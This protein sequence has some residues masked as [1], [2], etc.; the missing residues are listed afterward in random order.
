MRSKHSSPRLAPRFLRSERAIAA[1]E[2]A[3]VLPLMLFIFVGVSEVGQAIEISR[4]VTVTTRIVTDLVTQYSTMTSST[5]S[6]VLA[7]SAQ[8]IA[9]Y[10]SN[11]LAITVSQIST[12][13]S[14]SATVTWSATL[15]G[16]ALTPCSKFTL[17]TALDQ[18]NISLIYGTVTYSF[19]PVL[20][21]KIIGTI[22]ISDQIYMSPR[23]TNSITPT[24]CG[25]LPS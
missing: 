4:K 7:A 15:N 14:G 21:Y 2:F 6:T 10:S 13:A 18:D 1:V 16:T 12:N 17:P 11:N 19:T 24:T 22:P 9:P 25:S 3:L 23:L 20:G 8:V 5:M